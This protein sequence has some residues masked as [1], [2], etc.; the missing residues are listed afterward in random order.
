MVQHQNHILCDF[1]LY[2]D[3]EKDVA[4]TLKEKTKPKITAK[5][6]LKNNS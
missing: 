3:A 4:T 6:T 1:I 5:N 2:D